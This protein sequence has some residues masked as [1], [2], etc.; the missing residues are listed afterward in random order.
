MPGFESAYGQR[1]PWEQC[2]PSFP[3]VLGGIFSLPILCPVVLLQGVLCSEPPQIRTTARHNFR[4]T[5]FLTDIM[6]TLYNPS[7][8]CYTWMVVLE[9]GD[10]GSIADKTPGTDQKGVKEPKEQADQRW[11]GCLEGGCELPDLNS[12]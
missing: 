6:N 10:C 3:V 4:G 9:I 5:I 2:G 11:N 8:L 7:P 12:M 1:Q